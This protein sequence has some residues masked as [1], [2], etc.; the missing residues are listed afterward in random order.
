MLLRFYVVGCAVTV[1]LYFP[2]RDLCPTLTFPLFPRRPRTLASCTLPVPY[3][4]W[5]THVEQRLG[6]TRYVY[7]PC[8]TTVPH[9]RYVAPVPQPV[10]ITRL[11]WLPEHTLPDCPVVIWLTVTNWLRTLLTL[12]GL[13]PFA[14]RYHHG[15]LDTFTYPPPPPP[16]A[17]HTG[18]YGLPI[19][20]VVTFGYV[21]EF[22]TFTTL[23]ST[24]RLHAYVVVVTLRLIDLIAVVAAHFVT[25]H[26][27]LPAHVAVGC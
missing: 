25:T 23:R 11:I 7:T 17:P 9:S 15:R 19:A 2:V 12:P 22:P 24:L 3:H 21:V 18:H 6:P 5:P 10:D 4:I 14:G 27:A 8:V 13:L 20:P 1:I 26:V 16:P